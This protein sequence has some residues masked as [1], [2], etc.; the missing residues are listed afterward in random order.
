MN[1]LELSRAYYETCGRELLKQRFPKLFDRMTIGLA[2]EGSECFGFDDLYSEDH[3]FG[4][5]FCIW[6]DGA[7]YLRYGREVQRVYDCL[8]G[9]FAGYPARKV[10]S[11]G[12]GRVGVLCTQTWYGKYTGY[13]G[14]PVELEDWLRVPESSLATA[15]N[16]AVFE[17]PGGE[18]YKDTKTSAL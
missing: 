12:E 13:P 9:T 11:H 16:G 17:D 14:G 8:P 7:D 3:D 5:S 2:G 15:V 6:L 4:P 18:L 1:G 10:T